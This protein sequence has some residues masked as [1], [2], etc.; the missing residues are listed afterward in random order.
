MAAINRP[1]QRGRTH[2]IWL[3]AAFAIL[4]LV[5]CR[6][7]GDI[8][9]P[10]LRRF[11][12]FSFLDG[13]DIRNGCQTGAFDRYRFVYNGRYEEQV[14]VYE[15]TADG[16]GGAALV[17]R[18]RGPANLFA[19]DVADPLAPWRW[20]MSQTR[21]DQPM[22]A[23]LRDLILADGLSGPAPAGLRLRSDKF[24]WAA[25]A[26]IDGQ[27]HYGAWQFAS[28]AFKALK[29]PDW[30]LER[31]KTGLAF[32]AARPPLGNE[33][34]GASSIHQDAEYDPPFILTVDAIGIGGTH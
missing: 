32:N 11:Q 31:D 18:A 7:G 27:W 9:D 23:E 26:C 22:L 24:Y 29:F 12:W 8:D 5:G 14:R 21:L 2:Q 16:A 13:A 10:L 25:G 17:A 1:M 20:Q 15:V 6:Y 19:V 33:K 4:A 30:L 28:P 3:A 34:V